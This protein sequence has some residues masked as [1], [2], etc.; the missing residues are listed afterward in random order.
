MRSKKELL[1]TLKAIS[2]SS[3]PKKPN[4]SS[5]LLPVFSLIESDFQEEEKA[6]YEI[7]SWVEDQTKSMKVMKNKESF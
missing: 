4:T 6:R 1:N 3:E 5:I 7:N 2:F